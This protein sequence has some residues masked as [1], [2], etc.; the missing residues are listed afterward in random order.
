MNSSGYA[1]M[2]VKL[3]GYS[4]TLDLSAEYSDLTTR[5][6]HIS[7]YTFLDVSTAP[8]F[9]GQSIKG[10]NRYAIKYT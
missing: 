2:F 7:R 10:V 8:I 5:R 6:L 4:A 3:K 9:S 1:E